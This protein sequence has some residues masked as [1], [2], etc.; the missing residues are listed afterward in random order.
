METRKKLTD[1][2]EPDTRPVMMRD[3]AG[4]IYWDQETYMAPRQIKTVG[5]GLRFVHLFI[6]MF[7]F[8]IL[9]ELT[10]LIL[11]IVTEAAHGTPIPAAVLLFVA[12]IIMGCS[13]PLFYIL[14]EYKWQCTPGKF[15]TRS[16]VINEYAERPDLITVILRTFCRIVPFE[17]FS[18]LT[19]PYSYGWHDRWS[20][21]YV[22]P[23]EEVATLKNELE[24]A[25]MNKH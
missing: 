5:P 12:N 11:V 9:V 23:K 15:I 24:E 21:T 7:C 3:Y 25:E 16:R 8:G 4:N 13:Y 19:G 1:L 6:D 22:V 20:K 14:C 18:C 10:G 17:P 2:T